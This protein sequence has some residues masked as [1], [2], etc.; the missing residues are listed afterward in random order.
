MG[1]ETAGREGVRPGPRGSGEAREITAPLPEPEIRKG[2]EALGRPESEVF[3]RARVKYEP[4]KLVSHSEMTTFRRC[5]REWHWRYR[6]RL[7]PLIPAEA[8]VRGR[9]V[10][11]ALAHWWNRAHSSPPRLLDLEGEMGAAD[12]AMLR[13]YSAFYADGPTLSAVQVEQPF[14]VELEGVSVVGEVDAIGEKPNNERAQV[15]VEHKTTSSDIAPGSSYWRSVVTTAMQPSIYLLAFP[16]ATVLWDA[17]RKPALRKLEA[18]S[19][20]KE[21]ETDAEYEA[22]C[23]EAM[24]AE[25]EKYFQRC[26]VVRLEQ[27]QLATIEDIAATA[28][29]MGRAPPMP[30]RNPDACHSFGRACD[31]FGMCW[32]GRSVANSGDTLQRVEAHHTEIVASKGAI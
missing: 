26:V 19:K 5:P 15:I 11:E 32:E 25:P 28:E 13:G 21:P 30:A 10:H 6:E 17:L 22:R 16:G 24:A 4:G 29:A 20:R 23:V 18:N 14:R 7:E 2:W 3:P 12:R 9:K 27:E 31:F 1:Q 8:L